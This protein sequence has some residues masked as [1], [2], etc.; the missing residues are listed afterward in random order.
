MTKTE[1]K[2][3]DRAVKLMGKLALVAVEMGYVANVADFDEL[4]SDRKSRVINSCGK[5]MSRRN[6]QGWSR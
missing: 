5:L 4:P 2:S 1:Q 6:G 3:R